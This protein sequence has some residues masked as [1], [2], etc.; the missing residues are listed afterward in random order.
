MKV[1]VVVGLFLVTDKFTEFRFQSF[2]FYTIL[3]VSFC[4]FLIDEK[5]FLDLI[6]DFGF[7]WLF[8]WCVGDLICL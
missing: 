1:V 8:F 6:D 2:D 5:Q 3:L 4:G 7:L